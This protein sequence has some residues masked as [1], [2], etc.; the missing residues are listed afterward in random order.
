MLDKV[1][2]TLFIILVVLVIFSVLFYIYKD[3][4]ISKLIYY[5]NNMDMDNKNS[6][7]NKNNKNNK[8]VNTI[9]IINEARNNA[10][11]RIRNTNNTNKEKFIAVDQDQILDPTAQEYNNRLDNLALWLDNS[12]YGENGLLAKLKYELTQADIYRNEKRADLMELLTNIYILAYL[13]NLKKTNAET[14]KMYLKYRN[15]V[16]NKY[17][18]QYLR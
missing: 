3:G 11:E 10:L 17:Y 9:A 14:Y 4:D 2:D 13:E 1:N 16:N 7:D 8:P 6:K 18:S 5:D 15:P 12:Y